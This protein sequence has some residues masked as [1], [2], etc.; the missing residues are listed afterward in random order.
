M[1]FAL[2]KG[3]I[4]LH[5]F[6]VTFDVH[7][8][9]VHSKNKKLGPNQKKKETKNCVLKSKPERDKYRFVTDPHFS[10]YYSR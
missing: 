6:D 8:E 1:I 9:H 7:N 5:I 2:K 10:F 3:V 4:P